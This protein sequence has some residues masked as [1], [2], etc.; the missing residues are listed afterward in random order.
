[1]QRVPRWVPD[2]QTGGSASA[3]QIFSWRE[4]FFSERGTLMAIAAGYALLFAKAQLNG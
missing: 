4:T 2:F 3:A 1:V